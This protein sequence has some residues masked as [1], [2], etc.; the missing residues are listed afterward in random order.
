MAAAPGL[1]LT[2]VDIPRRLLALD[3]MTLAK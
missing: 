2:V 1:W 3:L